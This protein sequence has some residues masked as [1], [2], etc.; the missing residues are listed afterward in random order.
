MQLSAMYTQ[1]VAKVR[2]VRCCGRPPPPLKRRDQHLQLHVISVR[3]PDTRVNLRQ[4][5]HLP[6][7]QDMRNAWH[8]SEAIGDVKEWADHL[9]EV[10]IDRG[11][12]IASQLAFYRVAANDEGS[13][14][15]LSFKQLRRSV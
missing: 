6:Y 11:S 14:V 15:C 4:L 7:F 1:F 3:N 9:Q 13:L 2:V 5:K 10:V 12:I 8:L